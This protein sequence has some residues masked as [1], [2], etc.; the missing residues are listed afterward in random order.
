LCNRRAHELRGDFLNQDDERH[1]RQ[2]TSIVSRIKN[3]VVIV[4]CAFTTSRL[5]PAFA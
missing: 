5:H 2:S 4:D 3:V 1:L